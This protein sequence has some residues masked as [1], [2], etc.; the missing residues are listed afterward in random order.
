MLPTNGSCSDC[1][2]I[3]IMQCFMF[4]AL[5]KF[6]NDSSSGFSHQP[7]TNQK[8]QKLELRRESIISS[9]ESSVLTLFRN[10]MS[11]D[12]KTYAYRNYLLFRNL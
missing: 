8:V 7:T 4:D 2:T 9:C 10:I 6:M 1:S 5:K 12:D 11:K 3:V